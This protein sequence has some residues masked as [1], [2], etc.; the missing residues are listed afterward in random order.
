MTKTVVVEAALSIQIAAAITTMPASAAS[1]TG[2]SNGRRRKLAYSLRMRAMILPPWVLLLAAGGSRRFGSPKLLA[3]FDGE[4]LLRRSAR[5]ALGC[6]A[7]GCLVVLG[8][9]ATRLKREL[10]GLPVDIVV[11]RHW[12]RGLSASLRAGIAALP[13]TAPAALVM[14]ADQASLGP[15][16]LELLVAAWQRRPRAIVVARA[17]A[18]IG[19]PAI[20]P[21]RCFRDL[22]RLRGDTGAKPLLR[23]PSRVVIEID[24]PNATEDIDRPA[25]RL[26]RSTMPVVS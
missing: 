12:R 21:R 3:R 26:K 9:N 1:Q 6:R 18:V 7:A 20:F 19:P 16:D 15:A 11:N 10:R 14:L 4:S 17:G 5:V 2:A 13:A 23:D 24:I 22:R 25:D 8:A